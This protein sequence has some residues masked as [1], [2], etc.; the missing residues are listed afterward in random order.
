LITFKPGPP[1]RRNYK[2]VFIVVP[3]NRKAGGQLLP[4]RLVSG[5]LFLERPDNTYPPSRLQQKNAEIPR[6]FLFVKNASESNC[7]LE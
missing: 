4:R 5:L 2:R 1:A 6:R 7:G 3:G